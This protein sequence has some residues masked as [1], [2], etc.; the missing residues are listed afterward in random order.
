MVE[1]KAAGRPRGGPWRKGA[2]FLLLLAVLA[3]LVSLGNWQ[4]RRLH[5]KEGLLADIAAR[6]A[7]APVGIGE[8]DRMV[9]GGGDVDYRPVRVTG[10]FDHAHE[11]FFF[12]TFRG[13]TGYYVYTP[14]K[15][16]GGD[17]L[18]VNRGF[19]PY[20]RKAREGRAAGNVEGEVT[21]SGLARNRLSSKPSWFVPDNDPAKNIFYWKDI[22]AMAANA[23]L[24]SAS[25][26]P[27]FVDADAT[28]NPGGLPE[29]GVTQ[30]DFPNS[31]LQYA[32]TWYGLALTLCGVVAVYWLRN[33]RNKTGD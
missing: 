25:V 10:T 22:D 11:Q 21:V 31:H 7:M 32:I 9:A 4:V 28:P 12:A 29:G 6:R 2:T 24:D 14:M 17:V 15:L 30:F 16:A 27:F 33:N 18:F 13:D 1:A 8:I 23:G 3:I 19:V 26:L 20:D 5:W